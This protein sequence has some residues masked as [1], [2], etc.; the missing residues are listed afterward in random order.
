MQE[1]QF[2]NQLKKATANITV[3][4]LEHCFALPAMVDNTAFAAAVTSAKMLDFKAAASTSFVEAKHPYIIVAFNSYRTQD[5]YWHRLPV[6]HTVHTTLKVEE[7]IGS[8]VK[9]SNKD[10][11]LNY[12]A[13]YILLKNLI[14]TKLY[15]INC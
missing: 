14:S 2:D 3:V 6:K 10:H 11:L 13:Y 12:I 1:F 15:T 5:L 9:V 4:E 7:P 8:W